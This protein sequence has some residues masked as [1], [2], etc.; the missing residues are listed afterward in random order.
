MSIILSFFVCFFACGGDGG[1]GGGAGCDEDGDIASSR[2]TSICNSCCHCCLCRH[3]GGV[4]VCL[5]LSLFVSL[6]AFAFVGFVWIAAIFVFLRVLRFSSASSSSSFSMFA[7]CKFIEDITRH[8]AVNYGRLEAHREHF[9]WR[10]R[11]PSLVQ[12][13]I[14][15]PFLPFLTPALSSA[16]RTGSANPSDMAGQRSFG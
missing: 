9:C 11:K 2:R 14:A 12:Y 7:A 8:C 1:C 4:S 5:F 13:P 16:N 10:I 15:S 3:R 6:F